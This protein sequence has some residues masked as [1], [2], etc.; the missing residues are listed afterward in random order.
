V[1]QWD[2]LIGAAAALCTTISYIPQ[3]R[4]AWKT[5]ETGDLSLKMLALL[6]T[7]LALWIV[8]GLMRDDAVIIAA[9]GIS[10]ALLLLI[11]AIKLQNE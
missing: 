10:L 6:S 2:T 5:R 9:N 4:K 7:G 1:L 3:L 8:Y 11:V